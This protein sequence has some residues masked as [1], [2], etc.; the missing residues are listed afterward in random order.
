MVDAAKGDV[1]RPTGIFSNDE[2]KC[3]EKGESSTGDTVEKAVSYPCST[4][5]E[6]PAICDDASVPKEVSDEKKKKPGGTLSE[7]E[8]TPRLRSEFCKIKEFYS[9]QLNCDREG[10]SLQNTTID[11]MIERASGFLWFF[12]NVACVEPALVHCT[13]PQFVQEFVHFL[14]NDRGVKPITIISFAVIS[15]IEISRQLTLVLRER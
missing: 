8:M 12:K 3:N 10:S 7:A 15:A 2:I 14:M 1:P 11:K 4:A 9:G 5:L 6:I 13:N